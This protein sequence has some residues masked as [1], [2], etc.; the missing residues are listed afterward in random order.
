VSSVLK[1]NIYL[2]GGG[3]HCVSCIDV[4]EL[5]NEYSIQGI[6]DVSDK[7]GQKILGY[8]VIGTDQDLENYISAENYFLISLGQIKSSDLRRKIAKQIELLN[9]QFA[10]V[11][12][13]RAYVSKHA[14]I[15]EGTIVMHDAV[16][17]ANAQIGK[18]CILNTKC[19][20][21]HDSGVHDF[22]HISTAAV[23]NGDTHV[24][25]DSFIGSLAVIK[26]GVTVPARSVIQ[27]G[28][29]YAG[30]KKGKL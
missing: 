10:T 5:S 18:H 8:P 7:V 21:E 19:L 23:I 17:N 4:I 20:I 25:S 6:F 2:I 28:D 15:S 1:K 27:A 26:H 29:F 13:T 14:R 24:E 9:G 11:V 16:V 30:I 12:S 3:G 22:C